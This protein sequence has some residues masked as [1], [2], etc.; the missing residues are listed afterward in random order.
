MHNKTIIIDNNNTSLDKLA[1]YMKDQMPQLS[2]IGAFNTVNDG[3]ALMQKEQA[4]LVFVNIEYLDATTFLYL[5]QLRSNHCAIVFLT[6]KIIEENLSTLSRQF[7][8]PKK[9][10]IN[11]KIDGANNF[12]KFDDIIRLQA[13]G[14]Y[15][16]FYLKNHTKPVLTS[17]TL[18]LYL[19]ELDREQF[20]RAH[21]AHLINKKYIKH[22]FTQNEK[23]IV[24]VDDTEIMVS[25]RR[26]RE[27]KLIDNS[28][29][30]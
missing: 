29:I 6:S 25:R 21:R 16:L 11:L 2:L 12:I 10:G 17:K 8:K 30:I 14:N 3:L 13:Q 19:D 1:L 22:I 4:Q 9:R 24:L 26:I 23:R 15:T 28:P 20:F 18:K 5:Q 7:A 27:L